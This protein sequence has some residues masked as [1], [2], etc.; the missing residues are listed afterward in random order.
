MTLRLGSGRALALVLT[1]LAATPASAQL[2]GIGIRPFVL[3]ADQRAAA[4]T[5][6]NA[7]FGSAAETFW[8]GGVDVVYRGR[9]FVDLTVSRL[10]APGQRAFVSN[11]AVFG[12]G[13]P[14][15][16]TV[17]PVEL[18][19]G[20]RFRVGTSRIIPYA[21]AGIGSYGYR[22]TSEFSTPADD[23]DVR[24]SGFVM[25]GGA[26]FRVSRWMAIAGDAQYTRVPGILGQGGLSKDVNEDNLGGVAARLR[27]MVGR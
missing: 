4:K 22:E 14:L 6:F 2:H 17:T 3:V 20:Y 25:M 10:S 13:I 1:L 19:G 12:L 16:V 23:L 11:G 5:T 24:H 21:G 18:T 26:E 15:R 8:G 9:Y 7:V 27:V